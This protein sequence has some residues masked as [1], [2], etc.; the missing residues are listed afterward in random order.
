MA[1][2]YFANEDDDVSTDY[3]MD[4]SVNKEAELIKEMMVRMKKVL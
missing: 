1:G 3:P 4:E 2:G